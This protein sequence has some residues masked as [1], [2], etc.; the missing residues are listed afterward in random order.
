RFSPATV[1][2]E[3]TNVPSTTVTRSLSWN[4]ATETGCSLGGGTLPALMILPS[5]KPS[6]PGR[7][8]GST[9]GSP[10]GSFCQKRLGAELALR[11]TRDSFALAARPA[12]PGPADGR[13]HRPLRRQ[14]AAHDLNLA[15]LHLPAL[16]AGI[17]RQG[18]AQ[19]V[20]R[21][22]AAD[23]AERDVWSVGPVL[24][25]VAAQFQQRRLQRVVQGTQFLRAGA[26]A[27]PQDARPPR[28]GE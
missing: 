23:P 1:P 2:V 3:P 17:L 28:V 26:D 9:S 14:F 8:S 21:P 22:V 4:P 27:G 6:H 5:R 13:V 7:T 25:A 18:R 19:L 15:H 12:Q 11:K 24:A 16:P 20:G 10:C